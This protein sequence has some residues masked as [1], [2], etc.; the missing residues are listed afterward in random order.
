MFLSLCSNDYNVIQVGE[1][2]WFHIRSYHPMALLSI[3]IDP[4]RYTRGSASPWVSASIRFSSVLMNRAFR[5]LFKI[6]LIRGR[7]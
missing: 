4:C 6:E 3:G 2:V 1:S 5:T 7:G